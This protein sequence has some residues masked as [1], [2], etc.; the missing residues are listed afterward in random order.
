MKGKITRMNKKVEKELDSVKKEGLL[1]LIADNKT[2]LNK[3]EKECDEICMKTIHDKKSCKCKHIPVLQKELINLSDYIR[4]KEP[5]CVEEY[6]LRTIQK[7]TV[8]N[9]CVSCEKGKIFN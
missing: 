6:K 4:I 3:Y 7:C 9:C 1:K 8:A 2:D 5:E